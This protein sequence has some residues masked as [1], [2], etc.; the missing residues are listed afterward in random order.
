MKYYKECVQRHLFARFGLWSEY[1]PKHYADKKIIYTSKNPTFT[2]RL[3]V[4]Y[5]TFPDCKVISLVRDPVES[6]PSLAS[7][8][9]EVRYTSS[10]SSSS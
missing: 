1:F 5:K 3:K 2:Y 4:L 6:V 10:L 8:L 9:S 7:F